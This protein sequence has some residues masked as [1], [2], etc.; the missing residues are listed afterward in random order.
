MQG[1]NASKGDFHRSRECG[2]KR[3]VIRAR[4]MKDASESTDPDQ[5]I[6]AG[7]FGNALMLRLQAYGSDF[8][9]TRQ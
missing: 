1:M 2:G 4:H 9:M 3:A 7:R 8:R 5:H 6:P